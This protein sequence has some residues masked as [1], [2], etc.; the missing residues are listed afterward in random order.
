MRT[1]VNAVGVIEGQSL[2]AVPCL[3]HLEHCPQNVDRS[4]TGLHWNTIVKKSLSS[5]L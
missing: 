3:G 2:D 1:S 4:A 5:R